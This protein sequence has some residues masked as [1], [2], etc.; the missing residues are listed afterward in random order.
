MPGRM[1]NVVQLHNTPGKI[2]D[3]N[4]DYHWPGIRAGV[5]S[6]SPPSILSLTYIIYRDE[7]SASLSHA[8]ET[9]F[10]LPRCDQSPP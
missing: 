3:R 4:A 5:H 7:S 1:V 9:R 10:P 8:K 6:S 2:N